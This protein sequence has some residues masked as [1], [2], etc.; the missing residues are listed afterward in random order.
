MNKIKILTVPQ[1][2]QI[3]VSEGVDRSI[4]SVYN[5][6][7]RGKIKKFEPSNDYE[8]EEYRDR[9]YVLETEINKYKKY[10]K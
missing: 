8:A 1:F 4:A 5:D 2:Y 3:M 6:I 9:I 7:A 10:K